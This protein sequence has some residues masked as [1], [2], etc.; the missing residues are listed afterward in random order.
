MNNENA[1]A[2][3]LRIR[4]LSVH[5]ETMEG[6]SQ[7]TH[8]VSYDV[9]PGEIVG[10]VGESGSGKTVTVMAALGLLAKP[11]ARIAHGEVIF[12]GRDL[13]T[14]DDAE[15][16]EIRGNDI[17]FV[18]QDPLTS[19]NPV[20]TIGAHLKEAL[21]LHDPTMTRASIRERS[22][23]LLRRVGIPEA[24]TRL[25]QFPHEFSGGMRQ[26]VMFALAIAN[27]PR[28]LIADEPTTA[29]DVSVQAQL[30]D[31]LQTAQRETNA[32]TL[33]ITH[34]LGVIAEVADRVVVMYAG[35]VVEN[36]PVREVFHA[37]K[38]PYTAALLASR[39]RLEATGAERLTSIAGQPPSLY[40]R[41]D[42]CPFAPRCAVAS[43]RSICVDQ[44][45]ALFQV[46]PTHA[47]ACHF[48]DEV[49]TPE[50]AEADHG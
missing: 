36:A 10:V 42:G 12:D 11:P 15:L 27:N 22:I 24:S 18:F 5:F 46:S 43:G 37:P 39:P 41:I 13:L 3:A 44:T 2:P 48:P 49:A 33:L 19:F 50:Y 29:L 26:R 9:M 21:R 40:E 7:A 35:R 4:G 8:R 25:K 1:R 20:I 38:H 23:E 47:A 14:L 31:V 16:R 28:V 30:L 45:P 32:A 6:V 17:G 34:D